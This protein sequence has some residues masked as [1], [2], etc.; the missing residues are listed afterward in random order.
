MPDAQVRPDIPGK[1]CQDFRSSVTHLHMGEITLIPLGRSSSASLW[2]T[3]LLVIQPMNVVGNGM[4]LCEVLPQDRLRLIDAIDLDT[5][6]YV[7]S[8]TGTP[9]EN[10]TGKGLISEAKSAP[11]SCG[12]CDASD[13]CS[14]LRDSGIGLERPS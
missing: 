2:R 12:S 1:Q 14:T 5:V 13:A 6:A 7:K 8:K 10:D 11:N 4:D 3:L 9:S